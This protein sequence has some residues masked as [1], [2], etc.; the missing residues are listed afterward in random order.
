MAPT[1]ISRADMRRYNRE[2]QA[3]R[4]GSDSYKSQAEDACVMLAMEAGEIT[5]MQ[6]ADMIGVDVVTMRGRRQDMIKRGINL[7]KQL[8]KKD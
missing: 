5:E 6:A 7:A 3:R 8:N 1:G 2:Y 4:R